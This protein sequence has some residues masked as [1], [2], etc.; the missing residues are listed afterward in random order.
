MYGLWRFDVFQLSLL[1]HYSHNLL[2]SIHIHKV[3]KLGH[4]TN[5]I[6][7]KLKYISEINIFLFES[8]PVLE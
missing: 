2:Q 7:P 5:D 4:N 6:V 1:V 3:V 8:L